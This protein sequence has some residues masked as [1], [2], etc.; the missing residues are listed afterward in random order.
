MARKWKVYYYSESENEESEIETFINSKDERNQA[1]ILAW[2]EKLE[3]L[4]PNLPRPY[5]D[6][7]KNGIHELR[8]KLSGDQVRILYFFCYKDYVILT[9]HFI[10]RSDKVPKTEIDKAM[11]RR[12]KF[13]K[14]YPEKEIGKLLS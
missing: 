1:K 12:E 4:G 11:K 8:I 7:L 9:N 5:A 14:K 10:K 2:I 3:E 6:I 13:L